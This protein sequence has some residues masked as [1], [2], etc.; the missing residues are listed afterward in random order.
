MDKENEIRLPTNE[1]IQEWRKIEELV[2]EIHKLS[3]KF[4]D[5]TETAISIGL[6]AKPFDEINEYLTSLVKPLDEKAIEL[7]RD[8]QKRLDDWRNAPYNQKLDCKD[9]L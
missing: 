9:H 7:Q 1:E 6:D 8:I 3:Y 2:T 4:F 5:I